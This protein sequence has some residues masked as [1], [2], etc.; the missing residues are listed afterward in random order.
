[1]SDSPVGERRFRACVDKGTYD[2]V[3]LDPAGASAQRQ[4]YIANVA[5]ML[6]DGGLLVITSCNW[7][8][9]ELKEHFESSKH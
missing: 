5:D 9:N 8:E 4:K 3:S 6:A 7:T 2:A 1:M